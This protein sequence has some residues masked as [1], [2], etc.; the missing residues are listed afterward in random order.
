ML[1]VMYRVPLRRIVGGPSWLSSEKFD[2]QVRAD[3]SYSI[4]DLHIMF[5]NL[6]ADRFHLKLHK[7]TKM[8]PVYVLT[9]AKSGL[10]MISVVAGKDRNIPITN[11]RSNEIIGNR[12]RMDFFCWWLG[13]RL[14]NDERPVIDKTGLRGTYD[15]K[16]SFRP[17]LPP[18]AS[19]EVQSPELENLPSIFDAVKDQLGLELVPQKGPVETLVIDHIERPTEN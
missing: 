16:L 10:K 4:D 1:S 17:Q 19:G 5:Q 15:F 9:V 3:H 7:E 18:D 14:Q 2:V 8:G 11:G 12:V 13:L 6:L